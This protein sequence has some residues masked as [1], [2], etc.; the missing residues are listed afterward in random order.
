MRTSV[1]KMKISNKVPQILA[2]RRIKLIDLVLNK[3]FT[4]V[5]ASKLLQLK[6]CTARN[7][8]NKYKKM[9]LIY[10]KKNKRHI[11]PSTLKEY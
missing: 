9:G 2:Q 3:G 1:K 4:V 5:K 10:D 6:L 7:I 11:D 8:L